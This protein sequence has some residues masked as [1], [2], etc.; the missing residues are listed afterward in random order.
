MANL[1]SAVPVVG[2][3]ITIFGVGSNTVHEIVPGSTLTTLV[4]NEDGADVSIASATVIGFRLGTLQV[5]RGAVRI[6][7]GI[8]TYLYDTDGDGHHGLAEEIF[9]VEGMLIKIPDD[10]E[11][12]L[13]MVDVTAVKSIATVTPPADTEEDAELP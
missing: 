6:Y 10:G 11:G 13:K 1:S 3:K 8:P 2:A 4:V 5:D 12:T 7:D 9:S